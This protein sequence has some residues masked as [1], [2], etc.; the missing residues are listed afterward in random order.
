[1]TASSAFQSLHPRIQRYLW[2]EQWEALREVQELAIPLVLSADRDVIIAASTASGKTEAAFLPALTRLLNTDEEGLIVYISPLKALIN[3]QFERLQRL[4]EDLEVPVWPW[5]GDISGSTK[6]RFFKHPRGV[7]LI[8]PESLEAML[9]NRG[10]SV[11]AAFSKL[12]YVVVDEL[13]AFIGSERGKQLQ[14]LMHRIDVLLRRRTPRL[15]LSATL[16]DFSSAGTF[17]RPGVGAAP[18]LVNASSAGNDLQLIIKGYEQPTPDGGSDENPVAPTAVAEHLY[19]VLSG[20][21]NLIFPNSRREVERYTHLLNLLSEQ[22]GRPR[23]F[24]PHHGS[25]SKEIRTDTE[26]ALKQK[27]RSASAICTNTLE[28][29][30]DIGAVKSIAQIGPPPSVASLRQRLGRSGRRPGEPAVLRGYVIEDAI[31]AESTLKTRLRLDTVQSTASVML[32]LE[33]WFEPPSVN[34]LHLSTLI[35]Q[36]LSSIAQY[37]G[38]KAAQAYQLLC[39]NQGPFHGL[40]QDAFAE[41]LRHLG[42]EQVLIQD[43]SGLL[44]HGP[45][46]DKLVNHYTFYAAFNVDEEFRIVA[47]G[48]ALGTLPVSQLVTVGQRIL[49]GGRTW[50]VEQIDDAQKTIYVAA[51]KGGTPPL[52]NGT[53]GQ[54]HTQV[55]QKMR[56]LYQ[57]EIKPDFLDPTAS[58]FLQEAQSAYRQLR[59]DGKVLLDQG[60]DAL[61]LTW[62]GDSANEAI[63]CLL[64]AQGF[65][66]QAG[67]LGVEIS[68]GARSLD[69]V[70]KVLGRVAK[71]P[72]PSP[73]TLLQSANNLITQKWDSFLPS[74]LLR[75]SYASMKLDL[76]GATDWLVGAFG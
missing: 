67:R 3:D 37:G 6:Q 70:I 44:L 55:R 5:H 31:D 61:L 32:L 36:L 20:T 69:D 73:E 19:R 42:Q 51:A 46:G 53:G 30:I 40:S 29:G 21:N 9:C 64:N 17:L 24:W 23:E 60:S 74:R 12:L 57:Q 35:Q 39:A 18:A 50:L 68:K 27:G 71:M 15:G 43:G 56:G 76:E 2:I 34:G 11:A 33:R 45:V 16:G 4:C 48:K 62:L 49:F 75:R 72:L 14:S 13:H 66:S 1:M 22:D 7:L 47:A 52:F 59:L 28:L 38:L 26:A 65:T 63:A 8:T 41:L 58:R 25:L 10:T 54:V